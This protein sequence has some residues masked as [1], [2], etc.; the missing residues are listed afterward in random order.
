MCTR[1]TDSGSR[2]VNAVGEEYLQ[3][4]H[5]LSVHKC[6][7]GAPT[8]CYLIPIIFRYNCCFGYFFEL[9][10]AVFAL[11]HYHLMHS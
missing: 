7:L 2:G 6:E 9:C 5:V 1:P 10:F 11:L 3:T 4:W 8:S